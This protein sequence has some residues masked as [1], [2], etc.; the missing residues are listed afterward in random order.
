MRDKPDPALGP[1]IRRAE[2]VYSHLTFREQVASLDRP[3]PPSVDGMQ[4]FSCCLGC[5][6]RK[7]A[8]CPV[9]EARERK[10]RR[11]GPPPAPVPKKRRPIFSLLRRKG[12]KT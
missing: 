2:P 3:P 1:G 7:C 12:S 8:N 10:Q 5:P 4:G 11:F 6:G 9:E